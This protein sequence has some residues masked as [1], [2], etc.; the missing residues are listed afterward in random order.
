[1]TRFSAS[2][3][4][5]TARDGEKS[6]G[7]PASFAGRTSCVGKNR[8]VMA[9]ADSVSMVAHFAASGEMQKEAKKGVGW[10]SSN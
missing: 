7:L 10:L 3:G 1:L 5:C 6:N 2:Q 9:A 4:L 8:Q